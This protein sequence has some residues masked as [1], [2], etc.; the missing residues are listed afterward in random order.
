MNARRD[1]R[2]RKGDRVVDDEG[3][4]YRIETFELHKQELMA[5]LVREEDYLAPE[6]EALFVP[7]SKL[8]GRNE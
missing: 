3:V 1:H 2:L 6:A 4:C 5:V 8:R 7:V